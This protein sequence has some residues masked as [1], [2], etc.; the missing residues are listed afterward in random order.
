M[1]EK[2]NLT[3]ENTFIVCKRVETKELLCFVSFI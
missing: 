2:E 1:S 3:N